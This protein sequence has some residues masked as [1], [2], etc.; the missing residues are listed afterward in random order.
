M[1]CCAGA[2][3]CW[4]APNPELGSVWIVFATAGIEG[5]GDRA[6]ARL[7]TSLCSGNLAEGRAPAVLGQPRAPLAGASDRE[8]RSV[9]TDRQLTRGVAIVG[10]GLLGLGVLATVALGLFWRCR[11]AGPKR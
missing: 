1:P 10:F 7:A 11:S 6:V 3:G 2:W 8:E 5:S 4:S 9:N